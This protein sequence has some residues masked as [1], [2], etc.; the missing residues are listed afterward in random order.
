MIEGLFARPSWVATYGVARARQ[1]L[2]RPCCV[3]TWIGVEKGGKPARMGRPN[4]ASGW[5]E[6]PGGILERRRVA[7]AVAAKLIS[8]GFDI[9][10]LGLMVVF[11]RL[12]ADAEDI[13]A[14]CRVGRDDGRPGP[15]GGRVDAQRKFSPGA[16]W[17]PGGRI[18]AL[19][20]GWTQRWS[21]APPP[22]EARN[23]VNFRVKSGTCTA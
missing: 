22:P 11:R 17:L 15:G 21:V 8:A 4:G 9:H 13:P 10:R 7:L 16:R 6:S 1:R 14:T 19:G 18:G 5:R 20:S 23:S 3:E 12:K 2:D